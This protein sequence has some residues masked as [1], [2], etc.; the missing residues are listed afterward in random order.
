MSHLCAVTNVGW[1]NCT[2]N[3]SM[4]EWVQ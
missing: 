1:R 4:C 2:E 3:S